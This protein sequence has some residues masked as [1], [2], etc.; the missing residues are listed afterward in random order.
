M[1]VSLGPLNDNN[2]RN[3]FKLNIDCFYHQY[4]FYILSNIHLNVIA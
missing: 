3:L 1:L 4:T 2:I